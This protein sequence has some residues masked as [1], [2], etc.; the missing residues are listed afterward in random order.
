[1]PESSI[2]EVDV[3]TKD[4]RVVILN[5]Y[6][7]PDVASTGHLLSELAEYLVEKGA[8]VSVI[9][10]QPSYGPPETWT[11]CPRFSVENGIRVTRMW[12]TRFPKDSILGRTV[13]SLTF[14]IQLTLR[15]L[16]RRS[17]GEVF[18]STTNP[19]LPRRHWRD[20][21]PLPK[22]PLRRAP[23]RFLPPARRARR[24]GQERQPP[25]PPLAQVQPLHVQASRSVD[26]PLPPRQTPRLRHLRHPRGPRAHRPQLGR[27]HKIRPKPKKGNPFAKE[28]GLDEHF[29]VL[30]S[31]NLGLY[32]EFETIIRAAELLLGEKFRLVFIGAGGRRDWIARQI[33]ERNLSNT[34]LLTYQRFE[35]LP[36]PLTACDASLVTLQKGV[37]AISYPS[38]LYASLSVGR[39]ILA[40]SEPGSELDDQVVPTKVGPWF[41]LGDA[42]GL[43]DGIRRLRSDPEL[44][45]E[46]G[47]EARR[48]FEREYT[49]DA[50]AEKYAR[51][52]KLTHKTM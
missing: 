36:D 20:H 32:Y 25:R 7:V 29:T 19:P 14:L 50:S 24:Q 27:P 47:R 35:K 40:I 12:T 38:K 34:L 49:R 8:Q 45:D 44:C 17:R 37:E 52:F 1:M 22:A 46:M 3:A 6:Y 31:G 2:P 4:L 18:L 39:P 28:H 42:E 9:A 43:A 13:N 16:F 23:A 26:R 30:Y 11:D 51:V 15:V 21:L 10:T 5:Q 41:A 33:E 48:L